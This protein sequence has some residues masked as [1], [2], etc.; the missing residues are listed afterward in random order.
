MRTLLLALLLFLALGLG[1]CATAGPSPGQQSLQED[2][3]SGF[4]TI[5]PSWYDYDPAFRHW[6]DPRYHNPYI[7]K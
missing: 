4:G 2:W 5:P 3:P 1:G 6:Y 7:G